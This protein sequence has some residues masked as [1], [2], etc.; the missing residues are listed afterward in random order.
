MVETGDDGGRTEEADVEQK[1]R[2]PH[3]KMWGNY[4]FPHQTPA[5]QTIPTRMLRDESRH[6]QKPTITQVSS[7]TS[8]LQISA[9]ETV[10]PEFCHNKGPKHAETTSKGNMRTHFELEC[11]RD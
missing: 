8:W 2:T 1:V 10:N 3:N 6:G 7:R 9:K 4:Q 5:P 11:G